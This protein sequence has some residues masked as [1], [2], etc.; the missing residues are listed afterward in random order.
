[1]VR[2]GMRGADQQQNHTFSYLSLEERVRN[3]DPLRSAMRQ[4][5]M[6]PYTSCIAF[7]VP[8]VNHSC[9]HFVNYVPGHFIFWMLTTTAAG[10]A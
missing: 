4:R 1:M 9:G 6:L 10:H 7:G 3:N 5:G 8:S 2:E